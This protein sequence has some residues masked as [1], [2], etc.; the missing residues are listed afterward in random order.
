MTESKIVMIRKENQQI[1]KK[2]NIFIFKIFISTFIF[3]K[4]FL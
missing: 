2:Q 1:I 3:Y 4:N